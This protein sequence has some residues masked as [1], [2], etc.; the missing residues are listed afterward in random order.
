ML[1]TGTG[2]YFRFERKKE[3]GPS[4]GRP[5]PRRP[6]KDRTCCRLV[7]PSSTRKGSSRASS[8]NSKFPA[9]Q[10]AGGSNDDGAHCRAFLSCEERW[11]GYLCR[12]AHPICA[13]CPG[14][15]QAASLQIRRVACAHGC[16]PINM[17]IKRAAAT[18]HMQ[19][20]PATHTPKT[21]WQFGARLSSRKAVWSWH[22][23]NGLQVFW[24]DIDTRRAAAGVLRQLL[25]VTALCECSSTPAGFP[26]AALVERVIS[27]SACRLWLAYRRASRADWSGP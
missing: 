12:H 22:K 25:G 15:P 13:S 3:P 8:Y 21:C 23:L 5:S 20:V 4:R 26:A 27:R 2:C 1:T 17:P 11:R 19:I 6:I 10:H 16:I 14:R 9:R 7:D 18:W 24:T